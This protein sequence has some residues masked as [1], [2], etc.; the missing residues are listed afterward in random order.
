MS[1]CFY[2]E[3]IIECEMKDLKDFS[4]PDRSRW[5]KITRNVGLVKGSG[6]Q[7]GL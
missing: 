4:Q 3:I 1:L 2:S 6:D 7:D 5:S